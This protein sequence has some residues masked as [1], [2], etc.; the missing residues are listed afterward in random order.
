MGVGY[1]SPHFIKLKMEILKMNYF[2]NVHPQDSNRSLLVMQRGNVALQEN[3]DSG[4]RGSWQFS[5]SSGEEF[6]VE[7]HCD[8]GSEIYV[9]TVSCSQGSVYDSKSFEVVNETRTAPPVVVEPPTVDDIDIDEINLKPQDDDN[10]G[11]DWTLQT[12]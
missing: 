4:D 9:G 12:R 5:V 8:Q 6:R 7:L 1:S 11:I 2:V 3:L 10:D